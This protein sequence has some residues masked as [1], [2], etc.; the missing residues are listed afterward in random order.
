M[1][2]LPSN[3]KP[4]WPQSLP[5]REMNEKLLQFIW[6]FQYFS[7]SDLQTTSGEP[8]QIIDPGEW[9][10]NQGPD[11]SKAQIRIGT[12]ILAGS[13]ELHLRT[14]QWH[15]HGHSNDPN[16]RN[17]ILH[18][19]FDNDQTISSLPILELHSRIS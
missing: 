14:S 19:V 7:K 17:V 12:T 13:V 2:E 4:L 1:K 9:N 15:D 18:V 16:Y 10:H 11:F 5:F 6:K 3:K 8:L